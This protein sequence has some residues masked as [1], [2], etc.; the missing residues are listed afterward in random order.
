MSNDGSDLHSNQRTWVAQVFPTEPFVLA[1]LVAYVF[2]TL[3]ES[4]RQRIDSL[5]QEGNASGSVRLGQL[6]AAYLVT[7]SFSQTVIGALGLLGKYYRCKPSMHVKGSFTVVDSTV[8][9]AAESAQAVVRAIFCPYFPYQKDYPN[10]EARNLTQELESL[11]P[12]CV[13][14]AE[15]LRL[16]DNSVS[17]LFLVAEAAVE[18]CVQFTKGSEADGLLRVLSVHKPYEREYL[19]WSAR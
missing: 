10:L 4:F 3:T 5:V 11:K 13:G 16:V 6:I 19:Q 18:R 1:S 12:A 8:P 14:F 15:T 7:N 2:S 9:G 17:K